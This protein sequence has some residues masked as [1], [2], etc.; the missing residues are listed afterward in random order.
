M[1]VSSKAEGRPMTRMRNQIELQLLG[2]SRAFPLR[3]VSGY[4]WIQHLGMAALNDDRRD[5]SGSW[6][7]SKWAAKSYVASLQLLSRDGTR[8]WFHLSEDALYEAVRKCLL[9]T[10][11]PHRDLFKAAFERFR[12]E[13]DT[14]MSE[15][16]PSM[17]RLCSLEDFSMVSNVY[18]NSVKR[19]PQGVGVYFVHDRIDRSFTDIAVH[20]PSGIRR[21]LGALRGAERSPVMDDVA[22]YYNVLISQY[23]AGNLDLSAGELR[24]VEA[25]LNDL[26]GG[27][28]DAEAALS[29]ADSLD[30]LET[31]SAAPL[32]VSY[33]R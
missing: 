21:F 20:S 15:V 11:T 29:L 16:E 8:Q 30:E 17:A 18:L 27:L 24:V 9:P 1:I 3:T 28:R 33:R 13:A 10:A 25:T 19:M 2:A 4:N 26:V 5:V 7:H 31:A 6:Y 23:K 14:L 22:A 32:A 12:I